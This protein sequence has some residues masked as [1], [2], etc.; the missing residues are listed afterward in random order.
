MT[1]N[2]QTSESARTDSTDGQSGGT[3]S[4]SSGDTTRGLSAQ[5]TRTPRDTR[6]SAGRNNFNNLSRIDTTDS[7]SKGENENVGYII[8]TKSKRLTHGR[9][10]NEFSDLLM[11]YVGA[12]FRDGDDLGSLI[13]DLK[14]PEPDLVASYTPKKPTKGAEGYDTFEMKDGTLKD[15]K[16]YYLEK[17]GNE[18]CNSCN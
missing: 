11:T 17:Y 15:Y 7:S 3:G 14:D 18:T 16:T 12:E 9:V 2:N 5:Q 6:Q 13:R 4:S 1:E 10:F 8:G